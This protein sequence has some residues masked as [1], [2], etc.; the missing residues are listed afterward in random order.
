M[1]GGTGVQMVSGTRGRGQ[2]RRIAPL[3]GL[4]A[5]SADWV[6]EPRNL[7][8]RS[9]VSVTDH[10]KGSPMTDL[11]EARRDVSAASA[12]G[13]PFLI[14]FGLT[15]LACAA[16]SFVV[17]RSTAALLV[18][19][20]GAVALPASFLLERRMGHARMAPDNPLRPLSVQLAMSQVLA[21]PAVILVYSLNP[22][23]VPLVMA[24]IAGG[25]FLP[26][27][28]LQRTSVYVGLAVA[29]SGGALALQIGLGR[30]AFPYVLVWMTACYWIAA[31]LVYRNALGS[32]R[33]RT[34]RRAAHT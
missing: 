12:G 25:H 23:G 27:A 3:T 7:A 9:S 33:A 15:L 34:T 26:Y 20:Q 10:S 4:P 2:C 22:G 19:F 16:L 8:R 5:P 6:P 31:P 1:A 17:P 29:V 14:C 30:V 24:A 13:A 32:S 18:I 11:D 28:W 21:L